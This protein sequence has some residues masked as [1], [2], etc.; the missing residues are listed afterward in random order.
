[1]RDHG[2]VRFA[3]RGTLRRRLLVNAVVEPA[4]AA[5]RLPAGLRPH[6]TPI[7][8]VIGC[9]L[10][11]VRDLRPSG[12]PTAVG[13]RQF[14][15]AHRISAEWEDRSGDTILGV[16]VPGRLTDS[17]LAAF[18]GAR[19]SPGRFELAEVERAETADGFTWSVSGP[20]AEVS[21][22]VA[23]PA[24]S[25][26]TTRCEPVGGTCLSASIGLSPAGGGRLEGAHMELAHHRARQVALSQL[27]SSF[28]SSFTTAEACPSYLMEDV[29][30][31]WTRAEAPI[32]TVS[33]PAVVAS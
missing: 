17:H 6:V 16:Y 9:C 25:Q 33:P 21:V 32:S 10:L 2:S 4:E 7:G 28:I 24:G 29:A 13:L 12:L 22:T 18:L 14:A 20:G 1:M 27:E 23:V 31:R 26:P 15:T 19:S 8:T 5:T 11:E 3:L 30:V